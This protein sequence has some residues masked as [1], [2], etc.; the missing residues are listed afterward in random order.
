MKARHACFKFSYVCI[1]RLLK[2]QATSRI[3]VS[4]L[5]SPFVLSTMLSIIHQCVTAEDPCSRWASLEGA[6]HTVYSLPSSN[7]YHHPRVVVLLKQSARLTL[8]ESEFRHARKSGQLQEVVPQVVAV[9]II[10]HVDRRRYPL[11]VPATPKLA[12][13]SK[14]P[15]RSS[16]QTADP[17]LV[18]Q[19]SSICD[20]L[21]QQFSS[22]TID[23]F[24]HYS[25]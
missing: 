2:S 11:A 15:S 6:S 13:H 7:H 10:A 24:Q 12:P 14:T 21:S 23:C 20:A 18:H 25:R 22:P 19:W 3:P 8:L 1:V 9:S 16:T 4:C 5:K 17:W